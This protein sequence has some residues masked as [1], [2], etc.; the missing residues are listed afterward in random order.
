[1][2]IHT[3]SAHGAHFVTLQDGARD[4]TIL[5]RDASEAIAATLERYLRDERHTLRAVQSRI[6][7]YTQAR[8]LVR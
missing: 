4:T 3:Y 1:M 6:D 5:R 7:F 2:D 8:A